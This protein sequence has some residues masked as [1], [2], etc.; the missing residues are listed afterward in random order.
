MA[1]S[2]QSNTD[3]MASF[4]G[5]CEGYLKKPITPENLEEALG[6]IGINKDDCVE[7]QASK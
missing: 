2:M 5:G 7:E 6:K 3:I 4:R 1:T